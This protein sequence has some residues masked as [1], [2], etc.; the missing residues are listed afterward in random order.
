M[1]YSDIFENR[2][3]DYADA[4]LIAPYARNAE[5]QCLLDLI[6]ILP[7]MVV[8][9][10]PAGAGFVA[11]GLV[12]T[13]LLASQIICIE[14]TSAFVARIT[15]RT[16]IVRAD[17]SSTGLADNC[18]DAIT[19]LAG[20]HHMNDPAQFFD[21]A[22][23]ILKP[24][25]QIAVADVFAGSPTAKFLNGPVDQFTPGGHKGA[26]FENGQLTGCLS[27]VGFGF[28]SEAH[29]ECPWQFENLEQMTRFCKKL[30]GMR[31]ASTAN[32]YDALKAHFDIATI[33]T[34]VKL[35]WSLVYAS[36]RKLPHEKAKIS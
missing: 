18:V 23:R 3:V 36:A 21:E 14:P 4:H 30:F 15:R 6:S 26:F 1:D 7:G 35:P 24:N 28:A 32:I 2:G 13:G 16:R 5:R 9:D 22:F 31:H 20:L 12:K 19:S 25:G 34:G 11:E 8:C 17:I 27:D 29:H 10:M 33:S